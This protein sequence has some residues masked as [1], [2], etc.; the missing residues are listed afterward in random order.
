[1]TQNAFCRL[2]IRKGKF[3]GVKFKS[4]AKGAQHR[5]C[6]NAGAL[7]GV[8]VR[9]IGITI[10]GQVFDGGVQIVDEKSVFLCNIHGNLVIF[11]NI[12]VFS[13]GN[14]GIGKAAFHNGSRGGKDDLGVWEKHADSAADPIN[15]SLIHL[16]RCET[17]VLVL[18]ESVPKSRVP[19]N[20]VHVV[21]EIQFPL[22]IGQ[23]TEYKLSKPAIFFGII[24]LAGIG[25]HL[26]H[27][28]V[29]ALT[30]GISYQ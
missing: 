9:H 12:A 13:V 23:M 20:R 6:N 27:V 19:V 30:N 14:G 26:L 17:S 4:R 15:E 21:T 5:A 16:R 29:V 25:K 1:M 2:V 7:G 8:Q 28:F 11:F 22:P 10:L 24:H 3:N 18:N